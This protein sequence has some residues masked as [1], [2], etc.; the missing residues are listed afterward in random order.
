VTFLTTTCVARVRGDYYLCMDGALI[1]AA[2]TSERTTDM[3]S[4]EGSTAMKQLLVGFFAAGGV[5]LLIGY[6][7]F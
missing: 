2:R 6:L 5:I 4:P 7:F 3:S 1:R